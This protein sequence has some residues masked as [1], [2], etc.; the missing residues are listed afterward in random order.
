MI[1]VLVVIKSLLGFV[2]NLVQYNTESAEYL[3]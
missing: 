1:T 2:A 3:G